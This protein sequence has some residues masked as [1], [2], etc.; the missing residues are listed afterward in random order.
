MQHYTTIS[1]VDYLWI[2]RSALLLSWSMPWNYCATLQH[3]SSICVLHFCRWVLRQLTLMSFYYLST[4]IIHKQAEVTFDWK[5]LYLIHRRI[6]R[7]ETVSSRNLS[8][9]QHSNLIWFHTFQTK[10]KAGAR[11]LPGATRRRMV[12][13]FLKNQLTL[14]LISRS[15]PL[16]KGLP[17]SRWT[18]PIPHKYAPLKS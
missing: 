18:T 11:W 1:T 12:E 10:F 3:V 14:L 4:L 5:L 2:L 17:C 13:H 9:Y 6:K 7:T 8:I 16:E 15:Y